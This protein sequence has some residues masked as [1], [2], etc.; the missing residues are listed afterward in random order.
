MLYSQDGDSQSASH[1]RLS[2]SLQRLKPY[3]KFLPMSTPIILGCLIGLIGMVNVFFG[4][5]ILKTISNQ[6]PLIPID[7][8]LTEGFSALGRSAQLG[9]GIA[10]VIAASGLFLRFRSSWAFSI[11]LLIT[12]LAAN[13][14]QGHG[15]K[16]LLLAG[17]ILA[18]LIV[19]I[20]SHRIF[21]KQEIKVNLLIAIVSLVAVIGYATLGT[22]FS[23][24]GFKPEI[25]DL[26]T[27]F[28]YAV[29]TLTTVGFGDIT[30][31]TIETRMFTLTVI[32][33]GLGVFATTAATVFGTAVSNNLRRILD[34]KGAFMTLVDHVILIGD[35]SIAENTALEL[36]RLKRKFIRILP[37]T[38]EASEATIYG[39]ASEDSVLEQ[40]G[41]KKAKLVIAASEN[42]ADNAMVALTAK[43]LNPEVRVL[44]LAETP[45]H[46]PRLK[47]ARADLVF[48]PAAVGGRL[49]AALAEGKDI[50]PEFLDL[51]EGEL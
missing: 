37:G 47:R 4:L 33:L 42:D 28:Y 27:S 6:G 49:L 46:I 18:V 15:G 48:A 21:Y 39:D 29:V 35:G 8:T 36:S 12:M 19:L 23:G 51:L 41:I 31:V 9:F 44:A 26:P 5:G 22:Y 32:I 10:L 24:K 7:E 17:P 43:D 20:A 34:P 45:E 14:V 1:S 13:L 50:E 3:L 38:L 16:T 30:P 40:A 2:I 11:L 25:T